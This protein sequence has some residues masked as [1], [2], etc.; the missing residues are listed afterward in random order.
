MSKSLYKQGVE[1][2]A[3]HVVENKQDETMDEC[4]WDDFYDYLRNDI[5]DA[6]REFRAE[7]E[8]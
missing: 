8:K 7:N 4:D 1:L 5:Y 2:I 6:I 3:R